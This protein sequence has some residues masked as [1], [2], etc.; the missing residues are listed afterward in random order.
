[1]FSLQMDHAAHLWLH[2]RQEDLEPRHRASEAGT[3]IV[4]CVCI[5][6]IYLFTDRGSIEVFNNLVPSFVFGSLLSILFFI[7]KHYTPFSYFFCLVFDRRR[8]S[9]HLPGGFRQDRSHY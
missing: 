5:C 8:G 2:F 1:M 6:S 3:M 7:N 9:V 4:L